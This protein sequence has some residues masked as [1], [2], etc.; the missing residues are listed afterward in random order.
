MRQISP[1]LIGKISPSLIEQ[2]L[3]ILDQCPEIDYW[4]VDS[5]SDSQYILDEEEWARTHRAEPE[6]VS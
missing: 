3:L 2:R 6:R 4:R 5:T 1:K